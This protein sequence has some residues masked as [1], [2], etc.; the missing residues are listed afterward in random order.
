MVLGELGGVVVRV[1]G[2]EFEEIIISQVDPGVVAGGV[3]YVEE[4]VSV[5]FLVHE[6]GGVGFGVGGGWG[7]ESRPSALTSLI[8]H[9]LTIKIIFNYLNLLGS[10]FVRHLVAGAEVVAFGSWLLQRALDAATHFGFTVLTKPQSPNHCFLLLP[11]PPPLLLLLLRPTVLLQRCL[12]LFSAL[13]PPPIRCQTQHQ[14]ILGYFHF[15]LSLLFWGFRIVFLG[16]RLGVA[17]FVR[18]KPLQLPILILPI[19]PRSIVIFR[20]HA[21]W[22]GR[23]G[24][25]VVGAA[26]GEGG[27]NS[28]PVLVLFVLETDLLD[29]FEELI[30]FGIVKKAR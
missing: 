21:A 7:V 13:L 18:R 30:S 26:G 2:G 10:Q 17:G 22:D 14:V 12:L 6:G 27:M 16:D 15:F 4:G 23:G 11:N 25:G 28:M 5:D 8:T 20:L 9:Q 1:G 3:L 24:G 29:E 19:L